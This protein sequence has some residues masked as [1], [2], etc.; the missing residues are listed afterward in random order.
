MFSINM[1]AKGNNGNTT[2]NAKKGPRRSAGDRN[3][4]GS[5]GGGGGGGGGGGVGFGA[6]SGLATSTA[7]PTATDPTLTSEVKTTPRETTAASPGTAS[8]QNF[9]PQQAE[10]PDDDFATFPPLSPATLESVMGVDVFDLPEGGV[11]A[12][13]EG[14]ETALPRQVLECIRDRHGM[15][16][17]G[18]GRK[19]LDA[20]YCD[21][22]SD[23]NKAGGMGGTD[24][25]EHRRPRPLLLFPGLRLLHAEPPVIGVDDFFTAEECDAYV[26]RS[27]S[28][29]PAPLA[30]GGSD[31]A[32]P[33]M[34][35]SATLG[36]DVDSVAQRTSTTWFH[37]YSAVPELMA[38]AS[39]L[40][41]IPFDEGRWEEAQTVRYR[42]GEKFTWHLDALPPTPDL[43]SKGGQRIAT[44]LVYLTEMPEEDGGATAFRDL[45]PLRVRPRKGSALMFF[46]SCGGAPN[47]PFDI[48]TLHAGEMVR[49]G[50]KQDKW[51]AQLWLR[52]GP[53]TPTVPKGNRHADASSVVAEFDATWRQAAAAAA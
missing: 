42:P 37:R 17:F 8:R 13:E 24:E 18:G 29:A 3:T 20:E 27:L 28:P 7:T 21:P 11:T 23:E 52:E 12:R 5:V 31:V 40:V 19:L 15:L 6:S 25:E 1:A 48:R 22:N 51:I 35:R 49:S 41:G 32:R 36:A 30:D 9:A 4:K 47:C 33:H 53:Y 14:Q 10:L 16:E 44:L 45:G 26:S 43:A 46:P 38:K 39:A 34:Q 50:G 2:K